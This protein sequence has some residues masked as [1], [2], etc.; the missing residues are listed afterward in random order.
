MRN[1]A[2][3]PA[4]ITNL[5]EQSVP[6]STAH[7]PEDITHL[8]EQSA[9]PPLPRSQQTSL[10]SGSRVGPLHHPGPGRHH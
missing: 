9:S 7:P 3:T 1:T 5:W 4:D 10:M 2:H 8:W 6:P